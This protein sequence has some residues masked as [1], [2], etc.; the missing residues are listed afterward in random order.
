MVSHLAVRDP[1]RSFD[2]LYLIFTKEYSSY[3]SIKKKSDHLF[4]M[5]KNPNES[6]RDYV[7]RFKS[8]EGKDR[9]MQRVN[10]K[11]NLPKKTL[12]RPPTVRRNYHERRL[13]S[14][15]FLCLGREACTLGRGSTSKKGA[16]VASK[17][18][19]SGSKESKMG[20]SPAR[21][22]KKA[23]CRDRPTTKKGPMTKN[24]SKFSILIHQILHDIKNEP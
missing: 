18:V 6:L 13:N 21:A 3:H 2:D 19:G 15:R 8:R 14:S 4:N 10:S 9:R 20:N 16:R 7:K 12:S 5:K 17:R 11:C 22:D 24:Y 1:S 23:K